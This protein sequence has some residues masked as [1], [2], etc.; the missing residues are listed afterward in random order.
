MR[1]PRAYQKKPY[2]YACA[3]PS[4]ICDEGKKYPVC[5]YINCDEVNLKDAKKIQAWLKKTIKW[6]ES[7]K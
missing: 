2:Q 5:I 4:F 1:K 6:I 3:S 7:Q